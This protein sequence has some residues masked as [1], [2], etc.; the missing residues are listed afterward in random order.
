VLVVVLAL[1]ACGGSKGNPRRDAV[2][3]YFD[4]VDKAEAGVISSSG[5]IDQALR[6][7]RLSGNSPAEIRELT[8]ARGRLA[9]ALKR[10]RALQPPPDARRVHAD[11]VEL[12]TLQHAAAAELLHVVTYEPRFVQAL[13][14]LPAAGKA[15]SR[16][17]RQAAKTTSAPTPITSAEKA[18]AA[19]WGR[20]G[21]GSCHTLA[22][23]SSTGTAGPNLDVLRLTADEIAARVRTGGGGMPPFAKKLTPAAIHSVAAFVA[24]AEAREAANSASLEAYAA[25][26]DH[27]RRSL[28]GILTALRGLDAPPVMQPTLQ[29][30]L[31]TLGRAARLSGTVGTSLAQ[32][33]VAA[34]NTAIRQLFASASSAGKGATRQATAAAVEAYNGRLRRIATLSSRISRERQQLVARVG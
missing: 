6:N 30:E 17:I 27:Y 11:L 5:E 9:T 7:F 15:L 31:Q 19:V 23:V 22:A 28:D 16:D 18:G 33:D 12:L 21:C 2:N 4:K 1:A 13:A 26:F 32:R 25:A 24:D 14:P 10:V 34:A 29:A 8:F 20:A 3:T